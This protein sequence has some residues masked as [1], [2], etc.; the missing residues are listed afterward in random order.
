MIHDMV[1]SELIAVLQ[2]QLT[3]NQVALLALTF[4]VISI[5][6][7]IIAMI[8][9]VRRTGRG[10]EEILRKIVLMELERLRIPEAIVEIAE[11]RAPGI[12]ECPHCKSELPLQD[13]HVICPNCGR[14][15]AASE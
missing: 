15:L 13:I 6:L 9:A 2:N 1:H 3:V 7:S 12:K 8:I 11:A 10:M 5:V 4:G 14:L